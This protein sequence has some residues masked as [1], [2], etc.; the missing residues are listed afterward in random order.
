MLK[1]RMQQLFSRNFFIRHFS[2]NKL[3]SDSINF[4][5]YVA[6]LFT[7]CG[8]LDIHNKEINLLPISLKLSVLI[9]FAIFFGLWKQYPTLSQSCFF[10][11][12]SVTVEINVANFFD[13]K[14]FNMIIPSNTTFETDMTSSPQRPLPLISPKSLQGQFQNMFYKKNLIELDHLIENALST[15]TPSSNNCP[16]I[17]KQSKYD[18]GT[19]ATVPIPAT[20]RVAYF[21]AMASF[22]SLGNVSCTLEDFETSLSKLW[23]SIHL[24]GAYAPVLV[25]VYG[26]KHGR[27]PITYEK[28]VKM[29]IDSFI[30]SCRQE[31]KCVNKLVI[32]I[33]PFD[34]REYQVDF[35]SLKK[36][37]SILC[38]YENSRSVSTNKE[39]IG[40]S[41][42]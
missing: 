36:Y 41:A 16:S 35:F 9:F 1:I 39:L 7:I 5:G 31:I 6:L 33:Y 8:Y 25:P 15:E 28:A 19:I 40:T 42:T 17:C 13:F 26:V 4:L 34:L 32:V 10:E 21:L 20:E 30:T 18:I 22:N 27:L 24:K 29:I 37:L 23:Q 14:D 2:F 11:K 3:I 12:Q 38:D